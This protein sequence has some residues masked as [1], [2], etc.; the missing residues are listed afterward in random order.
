MKWVRPAHA[1]FHCSSWRWT[2]NDVDEFLL[3][4]WADKTRKSFT[5]LADC[6]K[7]CVSIVLV[8]NEALNL[9]MLTYPRDSAKSVF[10]H[11]HPLTV[12]WMLDIMPRVDLMGS[13]A[14]ARESKGG[15]YTL[16][17]TRTLL[18]NSA[19]FRRHPCV[20]LVV[21]KWFETAWC[22]KSIFQGFNRCLRII[23]SVWWFR[24][25]LFLPEGTIRFS[26]LVIVITSMQQ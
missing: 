3:T 21:N 4:H 6:F 12:A 15:S 10:S 18:W 23:N 20:N 9:Q 13:W 14:S 5:W 16:Q 25:M 2:F 1:Y 19:K 22:I 7:L 26:C 11:P 24:M 8:Y 17:A